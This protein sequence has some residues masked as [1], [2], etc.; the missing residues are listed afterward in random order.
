MF[1]VVQESLTNVHR[2]SGSKCASIRVS[3]EGDRIPV[4]VHYQGRGIL[5]RSWPRFRRRA[6]AWGLAECGNACASLMENCLSNPV[7]R[8]QGF[9]LLS[10]RNP[11]PA[12]TPVYAGPGSEWRDPAR[13]SS[14]PSRLP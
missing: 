14:E 5:L 3:R 9:A 2:H 13:N 10:L 12:K 11:P 4:E 8:A 6:L 7:P 1:R